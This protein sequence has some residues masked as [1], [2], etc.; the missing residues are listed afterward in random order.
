M[1]ITR[2]TIE[3]FKSLS[4]QTGLIDLSIIPELGGKIN[5]L[6]DTRSGREWL[7]RHP[8]FPYKQVPYGSSYTAASDTGGWDE[9]FPSVAECKYPSAPWKGAAIQDHGELWSQSPEFEIS[10]QSQSVL[11]RTVWQGITLPYTFR[12]VITLANN[13]AS[14]H[15]DYEVVN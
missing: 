15:V 1:L 2:S 8:R 4:I 9:C 7:W 10:E 5:S 3:G 6:R 12:R 14:V 13:S 11:L